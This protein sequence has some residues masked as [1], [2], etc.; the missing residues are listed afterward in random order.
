VKDYLRYAH[1][2]LVYFPAAYLGFLLGGLGPLLAIAFMTLSQVAIDNLLPPDL[3]D[4][5]PRIPAILDAILLAHL[6]AGVVALVLMAWSVAPGDL[7]GIGAAL[8]PWLP[9]V[10]VAHGAASGFDVLSSGML[11]GF[12][13]S[14]NT[15]VA[16]ELMHRRGSRLRLFT[17]RLILALNGDAQFEIAHVFGHHMN[18]ATHEDPASARRGESLYRFFLR[19]TVGQYRESVQ[20]ERRR[21]A[22]AGRPFWTAH[23]VLLSGIALTL[24]TALAVWGLAGPA[25]LAAYGIGLL[26]AKFM[27]ENVNYIQ[28]YG[29]L[30]R[31]GTQ[32][33]PRHSWDCMNAACTTAFYALSRHSHHHAKPVHPFWA[34]H[35]TSGRSGPNLQWGYLG[36]MM[37]AMV[38]PLWFRLTTPML[39]DWDA[40][41]ASPDELLL[42][43]EANRC[44]G[45][46]ALVLAE[47]AT[48]A[49]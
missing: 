2:L 46:P 5:Q 1:E 26:Y 6:P 32:V 42:A 15:V 48:P 10:R 3:Y 35:V 13:L 14:G 27:L 28:H 16:H 21:L 44:S 20:I 31:P 7:F 34:L 9:F 24:L 30:R 19:S 36:M 12:I 18:V 38:P 4:P 49:A 33:E 45:L 11:A 47:G 41:C 29:L 8:H 22:R 39:L 43:L 17:G 40:R 25:A 37:L 23:N